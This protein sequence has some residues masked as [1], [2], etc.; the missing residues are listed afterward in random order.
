[1]HSRKYL[2]TLTLKKGTLGRVSGHPGHPAA[3]HP[4]GSAP[5]YWQLFVFSYGKRCQTGNIMSTERC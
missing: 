1:M 2:L 3:G 4:A 5:G